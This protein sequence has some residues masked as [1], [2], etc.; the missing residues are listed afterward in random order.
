LRGFVAYSELF[1]NYT[2]IDRYCYFISGT[3][4]RSSKTVA[5]PIY[6]D[7]CLQR[8]TELTAKPPPPVH[9]NVK[10]LD[11]MASQ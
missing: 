2:H 9:D 1:K 10:I 7:V 8:V 6:M 3:A 4:A 5:N 11:F